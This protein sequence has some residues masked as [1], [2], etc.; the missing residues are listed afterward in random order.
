[1][2]KIEI[3]NVVKRFG[4]VT[5]LSGVSLTVED[6]ELLAVL[7]PSGA[8]KTTLL[9]IIAGVEK[10][11]AGRVVFDDVDVT[12]WNPEERQVAMAFEDYLLYP[13]MTVRANLE[14][15]LT[16]LG[17]PRERKGAAV[18]AMAEKLQI[19]GL[20]DR[21]PGQLSGGQRQRVALG[22]ALI[23]PARVYL[24]DEPI[25]HLDAKL[26]H[27][28]RGELTEMCRSLNSTIVY[29]THDYREALAIGDRVAVLRQGGLEQVAPPAEVYSS[30][31]SHFVASFVGDP[32][33]NLIPVQI[34][35][36]GGG[37]AAR[38]GDQSMPLGRR[39]W[40]AYV[41]RYG[42]STGPATLAIRPRHV[43]VRLEPGP[44]GGP[45]RDDKA[46]LACR[47]YVTELVGRRSVLTV[48]LDGGTLVQCLVDR[49]MS[50]SIRPDQDVWVCPDL[51]RALLLPPEPG[52]VTSG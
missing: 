25:A 22:R 9:R 47:A 46:A 20:L 52:G 48:R 8:G 17:W 41:S 29:V 21:L 32:P 24:L 3:R 5:A 44:R 27:R 7:G 6:R 31:A 42:G 28:M 15:S 11:T 35:P 12:D 30:P 10:P 43:R 26:R 40:E 36:A 19:E 18:A 45:G 39:V 34:L 33:M 13:H 51:D 2:A 37:Y 16:A 49:T 14:S 4:K 1:M 50:E 38:V 23:K